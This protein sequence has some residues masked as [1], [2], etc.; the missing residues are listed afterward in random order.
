[1]SCLADHCGSEAAQE[2]SVLNWPAEMLDLL[3]CLVCM[4]QKSSRLCAC[5]GNVVDLV[6]ASDVI[7]SDPAGLRLRTV[8]LNIQRCMCAHLLL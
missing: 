1:M 2:K 5:A 7:I 8:E 3:V 6:M 4:L